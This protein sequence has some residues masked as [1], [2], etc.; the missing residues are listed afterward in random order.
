MAS[1]TRSASTPTSSQPS[2]RKSG[3][4]SKS[5]T[6]P[7]PG[8]PLV[9]AHV[10]LCDLLLPRL[11]RGFPP[12]R[13]TGIVDLHSHLG[14]DSS[15]ELKGSDD[16]SE[17]GPPGDVVPAQAARERS[18]L[19]QPAPSTRRL[20]QGA[21]PAVPAL[22]RR[23]QHARRGLQ[24]VHRGRP[25]DGARSSW[26][27]PPLAPS[28]PRLRLTLSRRSHRSA[29]NIGGQAFLIKPRQTAENTP[30]SMQVSGQRFAGRP[31][32]VREQDVDRRLPPRL[33]QVDP[34]FVIDT[35]GGIKRTGH[36]RVSPA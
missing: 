27:R 13:S 6:S 34:P 23:S 2:A 30:S 26:V 21:D 8:S 16:T 15:P 1:F 3:T 19:T 31:R 35:H 20:A 18:W 5:L 32:N 14:V 24:P 11:T 28:P 22:D 12:L 7:A 9:R 17:S 25:D 36:W 4:T 33:R 10:C 29:N